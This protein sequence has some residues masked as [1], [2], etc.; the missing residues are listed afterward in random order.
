LTALP[1]DEVV[2]GPNERGYYEIS[3]GHLRR[4]QERLNACEKTLDELL[5][6]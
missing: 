5:D 4:I 1:S 6:Q 3:P 2:L